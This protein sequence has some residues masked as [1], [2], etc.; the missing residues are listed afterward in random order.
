MESAGQG[1]ETAHAAIVRPAAYA[2]RNMMDMP[3][4]LLT[5][6]LENMFCSNELTHSD[7]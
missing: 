1:A 5:I 2:V 7:R 4:A 3:E 6:L